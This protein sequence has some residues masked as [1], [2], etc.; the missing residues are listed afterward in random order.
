DE[1]CNSITSCNNAVAESE[2]VLWKL[3]EEAKEAGES[4]D[5]SDKYSSTLRELRDFDYECNKLST[6]LNSITVNLSNN[7]FLLL[8]GEAGI[9]KSHLLADVVETR[10]KTGSPSLFLL[11]QQFTSDESPWVQIFKRLQV[12]TTSND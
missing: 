8:Q 12:D 3:R 6:F 1:L 4:N 10:I 2:S 11:G 7:P 9:G 5:Y